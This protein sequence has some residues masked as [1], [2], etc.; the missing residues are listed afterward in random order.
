[1]ETPIPLTLLSQYCNTLIWLRRGPN[2][3]VKSQK[4][5]RWT[6]DSE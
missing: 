3:D 4:A 6:T 1:M 2:H 5:F